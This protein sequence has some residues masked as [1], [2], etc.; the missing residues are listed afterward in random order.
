[1][2]GGGGVIIYIL[3]GLADDS[4]TPGGEEGEGSSVGLG[5]D[6]GGVMWVEGDSGST[7]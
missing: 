6:L 2:K 4:P 1:M 3:V 7:K 5:L